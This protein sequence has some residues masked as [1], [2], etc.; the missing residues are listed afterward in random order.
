[1][2]KLTQQNVED[3]N[4]HS[5]KLVNATKDFITEYKTSL[6]KCGIP[7]TYLAGLHKSGSELEVGLNTCLENIRLVAAG[8]E[9]LKNQLDKIT[10][11]DASAKITEADTSAVKGTFNA[12]L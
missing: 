2:Q 6:N 7:E 4:E 5:N 8:T 11:T 1:M 3:F 10:L 9:E 12:V